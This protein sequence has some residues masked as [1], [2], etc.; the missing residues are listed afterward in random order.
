MPAKQ[1]TC[2]GPGEAP[3][4]PLTKQGRGPHR[5]GWLVRPGADR[6]GKRLE[7]P[8]DLPYRGSYVLE[9]LHLPDRIAIASN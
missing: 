7:A 2:L 1:R 8:G 6:V 5:F 4:T 3:L 9:I